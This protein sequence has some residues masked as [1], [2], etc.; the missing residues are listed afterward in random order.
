[1]ILPTLDRFISQTREYITIVFFYLI[2]STF[3]LAELVHTFN[4]STQKEES[5]SL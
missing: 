2:K 4:V 1:M 3:L 5:R